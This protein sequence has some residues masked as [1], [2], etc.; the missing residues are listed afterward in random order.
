M[1]LNL[2]TKL[3]ATNL[4]IAEIALGDIEAGFQ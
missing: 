1:I 3:M 2:T 4:E